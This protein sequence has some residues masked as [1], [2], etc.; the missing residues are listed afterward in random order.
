MC[1]SHALW[2]GASIE[3]RQPAGRG[4]QHVLLQAWPSTAL[5]SSNSGAEVE[6]GSQPC[7]AAGAVVRLHHS[8]PAG[9]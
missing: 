8:Q 5:G 6:Q 2:H 1:A 9:K 3:Q 4:L 7:I